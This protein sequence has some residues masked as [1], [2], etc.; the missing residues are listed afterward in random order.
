MNRERDFPELRNRASHLEI[1]SESEEINIINSRT[2]RFS[3]IN[4][5][6]R[7]RIIAEIVQ[8]L[9][10]ELRIEILRIVREEVRDSLKTVVGEVVREEIRLLFQ[11]GGPP[12]LINLVKESIKED[13]DRR[14]LSPI[15]G[16]IEESV[17]V[18]RE[19]SLMGDV[20]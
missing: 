11:E 7:A 19:R 2:D 13:I 14:I 17:S 1:E 16:N 9:K 4:L 12:S 18:E 6:R 8:K 10:E 15:V 20:T 3:N 5:R